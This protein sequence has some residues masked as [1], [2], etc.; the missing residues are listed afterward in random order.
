MLPL[1][2]GD[3]QSA[4]KNSREIIVFKKGIILLRFIAMPPTDETGC[5]F[6]PLMIAYRK[7]LEVK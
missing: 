3:D 4:H 1:W 6:S 7:L 5:S 2:K